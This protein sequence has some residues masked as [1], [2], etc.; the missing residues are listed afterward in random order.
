MPKHPRPRAPSLVDDYCAQLGNILDRSNPGIALIVAQQQ[1]SHRAVHAEAL[2]QML[3]EQVAERTAALAASN[4]QLKKTIEQLQAAKV[5]V[6]ATS[7]ARSD[8]LASMSH[9]LR[10]PLNAIIGFSD[11]IRSELMGPV[12]NNAYLGYATDIHFSGNHLLQI[13]NDIIDVVRQECGKM[14]LNEE[15]VDI[16]EVVGEALR[17]TTPQA[18][19][20]QVAITWQPP[21]R[22]AQL[23]CDRV[24]VR[25]MLLNIISNA[26]KFT[27]PG[28][29]VEIRA[30]IADGLELKVKDTGIGISPE[31]FSRILTPFGQIGSPYSRKHEGA[32]LGLTLTKAL[33]ERHGGRLSMDSAP[34]VGTVVCLWFPIER[35]LDTS[36]AMG[37][38]IERA[39]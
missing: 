25:Q 3:E 26:V 11:L 19:R 2:A 15:A 18:L 1:L 21:I 36:A 37:S 12:G 39:A 31:D 5:Q 4:E 6:E 35:M 16:D 9:E 28:G 8:F 10:T 33:I 13:I 7:K 30:E 24:R 23:Y 38:P 22:L 29:R 14:E 20:A 17:L 34:G 32:G 27:P